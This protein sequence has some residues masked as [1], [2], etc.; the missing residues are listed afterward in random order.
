MDWSCRG[1]V[2]TTL[3]P[4]CRPESLVRLTCEVNYRGM[5][6]LHVKVGL[7]RGSSRGHLVIDDIT[8]AWKGDQLA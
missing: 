5:V 6:S 2:S 1:T 8:G 3:R 4:C 7:L